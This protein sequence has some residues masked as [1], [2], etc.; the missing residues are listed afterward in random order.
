MSKKLQIFIKTR[1][2]SFS[3][4]PEW[5]RGRKTKDFPCVPWSRYFSLECVWQVSLQPLEVVQTR[6]IPSLLLPKFFS[7]KAACVTTS[8]HVEMNL[9][10]ETRRFS[11]ALWFFIYIFITVFKTNHCVVCSQLFCFKTATSIIPVS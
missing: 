11:T 8:W 3:E 9:Q 6:N 4:R 10:Q 5:E 2:G 1:S 7:L